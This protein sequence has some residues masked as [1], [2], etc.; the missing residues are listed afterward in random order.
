MYQG[1]ILSRFGKRSKTLIMM[2]VPTSIGAETV[3]ASYI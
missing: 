1:D 3:C 2:D